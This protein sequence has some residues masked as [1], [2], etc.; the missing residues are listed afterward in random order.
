MPIH[1]LP[2]FFLFL[3]LNSQRQSAIN[4]GLAQR[5]LHLSTTD[6]WGWVIL[7]VGCP[8]HGRTFNSISGLCSL[9]ARN[10][11]HLWQLK[12]C[13]DTAKYPPRWEW[14][15]HLWLAATVPG[16]TLCPLDTISLVH[17]RLFG[18]PPDVRCGRAWSLQYVKGPVGPMLCPPLEPVNLHHHPRQSSEPRKARH[19][20]VL[21]APPPGPCIRHLW[22]MASTLE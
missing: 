3:L 11:L 17:P 7:F 4:S 13:P 19:P 18:F 10:I 16:S 8:L 2:V 14:R 9:N 1:S 21:P 12:I 5:F 15:G 20:C 22:S 6:I